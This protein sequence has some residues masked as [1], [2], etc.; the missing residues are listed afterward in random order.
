L[1]LS[2]CFGFI[3]I[4]SCSRLRSFY[5]L[6]DRQGQRGVFLRNFFRWGKLGKWNFASFPTSERE[7][8]FCV[9]VF[10]VAV[11]L[12]FCCCLCRVVLSLALFWFCGVAERKRLLYE[13]FFSPRGQEKLKVSLA[14]THAGVAEQTAVCHV[15]SRVG[16]GAKKFSHGAWLK[17]KKEAQKQKIKK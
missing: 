13:N 12:L 17:N 10:A 16:A 8:I 2:F 5:L 11:S 4:V 14:L 1:L 7:P 6:G 9:V 3:V 15:K